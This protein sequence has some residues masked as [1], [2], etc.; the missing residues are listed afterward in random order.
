M[1]TVEAYVKQREALMEQQL[2]TGTAP[3]VAFK[4]LKFSGENGGW[5]VDG[6]PIVP[7]FRCIHDYHAKDIRPLDQCMIPET[8]E[9]PAG[10]PRPRRILFPIRSADDQEQPDLHPEPENDAEE[11]AG[12]ERSPPQQAPKHSELPQEEGSG[13]EEEEEEQP[14]LFAEG[15]DESDGDEDEDRTPTQ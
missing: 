1:D 11:A 4:P 6:L 12:V 8:P 5:G 10:E 2:R 14:E 9:A 15:E 3:K 7:G 13:T